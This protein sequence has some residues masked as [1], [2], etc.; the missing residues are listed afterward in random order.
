MPASYDL[1]LV[2]LSLAIAMVAAYTALDLASRIARET[3]SLKRDWLIAGAFVLGI[4]I[5]AMHFI[6]MLAFADA[7]SSANVRIGVICGSVL[8]A[9]DGYTML[10]AVSP[11]RQTS[12]STPG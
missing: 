8:S 7:A 2:I 11:N 3:G 1:T 5:W 9:L 12:A 6:G 4:G 10:R